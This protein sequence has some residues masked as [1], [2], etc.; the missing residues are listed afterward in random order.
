MPVMALLIGVFLAAACP[1]ALAAAPTP[2]ID[3]ADA[4]DLV[5]TASFD[6]ASESDRSVERLPPDSYRRLRTTRAGHGS[7]VAV[8]DRIDSLL[9]LGLSEDSLLTAVVTLAEDIAVPRL[10]LPS[11]IVVDGT[12]AFAPASSGPLFL[13]MLESRR[14]ARYERLAGDLARETEAQVLETFRIAPAAVIRIRKDRLR[15]LAEW[16]DVVHI[17]RTEI[18][19]PT[20]LKFSDS[21]VDTIPIATG[22]SRIASDQYFG[23]HPVTTR[24][25]ILDTGIDAD[26]RDF[27]PSPTRIGLA[28]DCVCACPNC[29]GPNA[30]DTNTEKHGTSTAAILGARPPGWPE[31]QGVTASK[32]DCFR[33]YG[34]DGE[35]LDIPATIRAFENSLCVDRIIV[36]EMDEVGIASIEV[37]AHNATRAGALVVAAAGNHGKPKP[38][39][40][41]VG[42]PAQARQVIAV[43]AYHV[44]DK[45]QPIYEGTSWGMSHVGGR[46]K[47]DL[48]APT[49]CYAVIGPHTATSGATPFAAGAAALLRDWLVWAS[50][51][52]DV[53]PGQVC[54]QLI[55]SGNVAG[56]FEG[57]TREGVG[58]IVLPSNGNCVFGKIR[59]DEVAS[60]CEIPIKVEAGIQRFDAA[61]WWPEE[62]VH[63]RGRQLD[64]HNDINL[65]L[66]APNGKV[67][68]CSRSEGG[69]FERTSVP[70]SVAPGTWLVRVDAKTIRYGPQPVYWTVALRTDAGPPVSRKP[71]E[72]QPAGR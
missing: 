15:R 29:D 55:L 52:T 70:G 48:M 49:D 67:V 34:D 9:G 71:C 50:N 20:I 56:P 10:F 43:G 69:V 64:T 16:P 41:D 62:L 18:P 5:T 44:G 45:K 66:V 47:P 11:T 28:R 26:H 4:F 2:I 25:G 42:M 54:A 32:L 38:Y 60:R 22:R 1:S 37:A 31:G 27:G 23:R 65:E 21:G 35:R 57:P 36:A 72:D 51:G 13:D 40:D 12:D 7:S 63:E 30:R 3:G 53:D 61:L 33:V 24:I 8:S 46:P 58:R 68:A 19:S 17:G 14:K 59:I 6:S 39:F